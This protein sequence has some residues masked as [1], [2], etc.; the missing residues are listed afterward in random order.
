MCPFGGIGRAEKFCEGVVGDE[1]LAAGRAGFF[2]RKARGAVAGS[3]SGA[4]DFFGRS[5][6]QDGGLGRCED[7]E[8]REKIADISRG[9]FFAFGARG[10]VLRFAFGNGLRFCEDGAFEIEGGF[11]GGFEN[12]FWNCAGVSS[13]FQIFFGHL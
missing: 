11:P 3:G 8:E 10:G 4:S 13:F 12:V 9:D 6:P 7:E 2:G 5:L 1:V